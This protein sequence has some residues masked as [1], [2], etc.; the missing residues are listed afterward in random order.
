MEEDFLT[1]GDLFFRR[2]NRDLSPIDRF[3]LTGLMDAVHVE[4]ENVLNK[5]LITCVL[6]IEEHGPP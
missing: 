1:V 6:R 4:W 2:V 3:K 5:V